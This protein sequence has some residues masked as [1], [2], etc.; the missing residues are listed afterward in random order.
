ME[1]WRGE[2]GIEQ[3]KVDWPSFSIG[4]LKANGDDDDDDIL[5]D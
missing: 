5:H 2:F 3:T 4:Q 1:W